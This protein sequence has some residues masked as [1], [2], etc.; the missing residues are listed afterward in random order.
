M[1]LSEIVYCHSTN[2]YKVV[3]NGVTYGFT[4]N[5][6]NHIKRLSRGPQGMFSAADYYRGLSREEKKK[7]LI[8]GANNAP[9]E[10]GFWPDIEY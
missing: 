8:I 5:H 10:D 9:N 3:E 7:V 1:L 6:V 2:T 4:F